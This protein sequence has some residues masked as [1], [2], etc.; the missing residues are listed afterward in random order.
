MTSAGFKYE[1][2]SVELKE[3][4]KNSQ[5]RI[6]AR[7]GFIITVTD[8]HN[9]SGRGETAPLPGLS[10][11]T[12][13]S[14]GAELDNFARIISQL[15][16]LKD[17]SSVKNIK[18][19]ADASPS[20]RF[21]IEQALFNLL[22]KRESSGILNW[23]SPGDRAINVNAVIGLGEDAGR[24]AEEKINAGYG[25]IKLKA[26]RTGFD[27]DLSIIKELRNR[28][29]YGFN[30]RIDANGKW[31]P[32]E[33]MRNLDDLEPYRIEY[34]EEPCP[35]LENLVS[36][37]SKSP[38]PVAADESIKSV[39]DALAVLENSA[40]P[41]VVLKPMITG[42]LTGTLEIIEKASLLDKNIIIS[43]SFETALGRNLLVLLA[44][45]VKHNYAHGLDTGDFLTEE[46]FA[47]PYKIEKGIINFSV[48]EFSRGKI[49]D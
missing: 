29:G 6:T 4:F 12:Y 26:G 3:P 25:T 17:F 13:E 43:S 1:P 35:G 30:L 42:G 34:V 5:Y 19:L 44:S 46:L 7:R 41:F 23:L 32:E 2:F 28:L 37:A 33:A 11:E 15:P 10:I 16:K 36:I 45:L 18:E 38:V 14:A 40:I 48:K 49:G 39:T 21:G 8:E 31:S 24:R 47:D 27:D 9:N 22:L 20:V